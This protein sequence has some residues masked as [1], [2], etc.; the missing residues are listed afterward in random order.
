MPKFSKRSSRPYPIPSDS[1]MGLCQTTALEPT[2]RLY[3]SLNLNRHL[4]YKTFSSSISCKVDLRPLESQYGLK[5]D[6]TKSYSIIWREIGCLVNFI[7][8][9]DYPRGQPFV[10]PDKRIYKIESKPLGNKGETQEDL[11]KLI[12]EADDLLFSDHTL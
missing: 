1:M 4:S 12:Q 7:D 2:I 11:S 3:K 6:P 9:K 8:W 5:V 10:G